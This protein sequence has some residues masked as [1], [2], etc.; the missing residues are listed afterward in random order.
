MKATAPHA[1]H[2][3]PGNFGA[4]HGGIDDTVEGDPIGLESKGNQAVKHLQGPAGIAPL[5][6][7]FHQSVV[8]DHVAKGRGGLLGFPNEGINDFNLICC[9]CC[10]Q[11]DVQGERIDRHSPGMHIPNGL[12]RRPP[13]RLL[14]IHAQHSHVGPNGRHSNLTKLL[15]EG[16]GKLPVPNLDC[17]ADETAVGCGRGRHSICL[18]MVVHG[19]G[20]AEMFLASE[21][22]HGAFVAMEAPGH[23]LLRHVGDDGL[24]GFAGS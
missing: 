19:Q 24:H 18:D 8:R 5:H 3:F 9:H 23:S 14:G 2:Q 13:V 20:K 7:A 1:G 10:C 22:L 6:V 12:H 16:P 17:E 21:L 4:A 15:E 11:H